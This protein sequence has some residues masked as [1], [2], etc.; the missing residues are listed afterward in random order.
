MKFYCVINIFDL[1]TF[2]KET[3]ALLKSFE[4]STEMHFIFFLFFL[5][6]TSLL[7]IHLKFTVV[8][9]ADLNLSSINKS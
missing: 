1:N 5:N 2:D 7:M 9:Y 4:I 8:N 3:T 6:E